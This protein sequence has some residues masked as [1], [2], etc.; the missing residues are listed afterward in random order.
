MFF[1]F[2]KK[3]ITVGEIKANNKYTK[4]NKMLGTAS[5]GV[6]YKSYKKKKTK[7]YLVYG[8]NKRA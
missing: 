6:I 7:N 5:C 1:R 3:D 8:V 4:P 2:L